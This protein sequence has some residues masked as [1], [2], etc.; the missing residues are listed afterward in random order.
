MSALSEKVRVALYAKMNVVGVT[1][2]ATG[3]IH[4]LVAPENAV[5]PYIV[6]NR[7]AAADVTRA[8]Q[9]NLIA[10]ND[11]WLIK[12]I[13]DE[14]SST[15]KEPQ[16]LNQDILTAVETAIGNSLTLTG[17]SETWNVERVSDIPESIETRN[18]RAIYYNGFLLEIWSH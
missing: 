11:V 16:Q 7:Q 5:K 8:F 4:H 2:L 3:G 9:N 18:D 17:G 14:D 15:T 13:S 12:A 1:S 10:E 6:F